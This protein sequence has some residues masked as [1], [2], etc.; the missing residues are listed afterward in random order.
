[1]LERSSERR[2]GPLMFVADEDARLVEVSAGWDRL[3]G[4]EGESL[5]GSALLD[6]VHPEDRELC[7]RWLEGVIEGEA[8]LPARVRVRRRDGTF[9]L[10]EFVGLGTPRHRLA[11]AAARELRL[12]EGTPEQSVVAHPSGLQV[13]G[14]ARRVTV[15]GEELQLT[16]SEFDLLALLM[17][18]QGTVLSADR[19]AQDVW[20]YRTAGS[21]NF[22]QAHISRLRRKLSEAGV[23][24]LIGTVR[25]YGYVIR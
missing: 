6:H 4:T 1:M 17:R 19:I 25:G 16:A 14:D 23:D 5:A 8:A 7:E 3:L 18:N 2:D 11:F 12:S 9:A 13:D 10:L 22:L 21:R 15:G 24:G 20:A